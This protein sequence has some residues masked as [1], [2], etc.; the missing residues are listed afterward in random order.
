MQNIFPQ[1][2]QK[3]VRRPLSVASA[4]S[5]QCDTAASASASVHESDE[6]LSQ[7]FEERRANE[8]SSASGA[9][10]FEGN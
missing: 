5:L 3:A 1:S 2:Q 8:A 10:E 6:T 7:K 4:N 9:V